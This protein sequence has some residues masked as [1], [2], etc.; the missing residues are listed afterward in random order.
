VP[1]GDELGVLA[2]EGRGA[3][4]SSWFVIYTYDASGFVRDDEKGALDA[5]AILA[6]IRRGTEAANEGRRA[7][8]VRDD[9]RGMGA[10]PALR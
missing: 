9:G 7:R 3:E 10:A 2:C 8:V 5:D 4:A 1:S 6:S